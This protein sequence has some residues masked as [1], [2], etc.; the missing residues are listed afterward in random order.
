VECQLDINQTRLDIH[1]DFSGGSRFTCPDCGQAN[2]AVHDTVPKSWRHLNFFQ[3]DAFIHARVPRIKCNNCGI[4]VDHVPWAREDCKFMLLSEAYIMLLVPSMPVKRIS[5]LV[6]EHDTR[7]W[8]LIQHHVKKARY[9]A[10]YA[11]VKQVGIDETSSKRGHNYVTLVVDLEESKTI[12]A[13]EGK[14]T[15]PL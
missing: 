4:R 3:H 7:L 14:E 15:L 9:E 8:R 6:G 13:F 12:F 1:L 5:E 2:S 10:D 11:N